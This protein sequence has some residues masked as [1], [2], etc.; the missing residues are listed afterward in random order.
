MAQAESCAVCHEGIGE[1]KHQSVYDKYVDA[2]TL[3]LTFTDVSSAMIGAGDYTVTLEFSITKNGL[4]FVD[5]AGL[6]AMDQKRFYAVQYDSVAKQYLNGNTRLRE[7]NVVPV[8]GQ[9]GDYILTQTGVPFAPE[10]PT[11]V[12]PFDGA[13]VYGYIAQG[14]LL[15]HEGGGSGELPAGS[16]VHLYDDV[17]NTAMAFGTA[18]S[19]VAGAYDSAANV[20]GCENC[21]GTPYMKHGYRDPIVAGLPDFGSCKSCH[22]DDRTGG[23]EDWQYMVDDPSNWGTAGLPTA[24]VETTYGYK[25]KLMNDVHM[26]HAME[27]PYPRSMANC[28]TCH[29]GKLDRI[30]TD[31]NFTPE[32]CK[33]CHPVDGNDTW[34]QTFD[35]AGNEILDSRGRRVPEIYAQIER[36]PALEYLWDT[37]ATNPIF[38]TPI[39]NDP[40]LSPTDCNEACHREGG[41]APVF[42]ELHT[43]YD[44]RIDNTAGVAYAD[45]FSASIDDVAVDLV[46][47]TMT[48][49]YSADASA[50]ANAVPD[51][52]LN[53]HVYVSF[54][55]WDSKHFIVPSH[56]RDANRLRYEFSPGNTNVLFPTFTEVAPGS[57]EL[58]VDMTAWVGGQPGAIPDLIAEGTIKKAMITLA[59]RLDVDIGRSYRNAAGTT[60][61][62]NL[63]AVTRAVDLTTG[64]FVDDY[65]SGPEAIV[66]VEN[67]CNN[68]HDQLAVTWHTG[69]GRGGDIIACKNCHNPTYPGSHVEMASRSVESYVHAIHSF[70]DFDVDDVFHDDAEPGDPA[71]G[72][73]FD[74]V[75]AKRYDQHINHTFPNFTIRNCEACHVEGT[76]DVPD[77]SKSIPGVL[78]AAQTVD[79]WYEMIDTPDGSIPDTVAVL[80][81]AR[82]IGAIPETV[83][84]PASRACGGCHRADLINADDAGG[85]AA[86]NAHTEAFGSFVENE[87]IDDVED[88]ILFGIIDKIMSMFQ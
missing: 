60:I 83:V 26:A 3:A 70:Q 16:H 77:Q 7:S 61:A 88:Q 78:S 71:H 5:T 50:I 59:P 38:H 86:W 11:W 39:I 6:P 41:I 68:C 49:S 76:F 47:N 64:T 42:S 46:A 81:D 15:T 52:P 25:A 34:P 56:T 33:S 29:E 53:V 67:G 21:H 85:L 74:A 43:G 17:S 2:S 12:A 20:S 55:G 48:I 45:L 44:V 22:Y 31:A 28:S 75:L 27:F 35:E 32:T 36:A 8:A 73:D 18:V 80:I 69:S 23:H 19:G 13:Q 87:E 82:N 63:N 72:E 51:A 65:F 58:M 37:N 10:G 9:P 62:A 54:F 14:A 84:G 4:P 66:D 30:L 1:G 79:N 40:T 57:Y 24:D